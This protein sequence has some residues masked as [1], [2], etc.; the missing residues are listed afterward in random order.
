MVT[1]YFSYSSLHNIY[2][3]K[4]LDLLIIAVQLQFWIKLI[5]QSC[6]YH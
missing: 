6:V 3:T 4:Y 2:Y 1:L 5:Q